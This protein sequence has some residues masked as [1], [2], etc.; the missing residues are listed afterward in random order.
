MRVAGWINQ[1]GVMVTVVIPKMDVVLIALAPVIEA[2]NPSLVTYS[3]DSFWPYPIVWAPDFLPSGNLAHCQIIFSE[4]RYGFRR[5]KPPW[6][7]TEVAVRI[8][9]NSANAVGFTLG[10]CS[11]L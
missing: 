5:L 4:F 9:I 8:A 1:A 10:I 3:Q 2:V 7:A 6:A 11:K